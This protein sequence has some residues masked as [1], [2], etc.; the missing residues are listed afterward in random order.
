MGTGVPGRPVFTAGTSKS[1]VAR[2][3][4]ESRATEVG[5]RVDQLCT[6]SV[7]TGLVPFLWTV[8]VLTVVS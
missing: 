5:F 6:V 1:P 4:L 7:S 2:D 3:S 8:S